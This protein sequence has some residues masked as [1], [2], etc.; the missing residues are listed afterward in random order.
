MDEFRSV[1]EREKPQI[2]SVTETWGKEWMGEAIFSLN[3]YN[4]YRDDRNEKGGG[5]TLLY[6]SKKLGQ[7]AC[8]PLNE[9]AQDQH[10][11]SNIWCW[12]TPMNNSKKFLVGSIY[13]STSSS[14]ENNRLLLKQLERA[15]DIAGENRVLIMGDFNIPDVDWINNDIMVVHQK[16]TRICT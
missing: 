1:I 5:G 13:R 3:D 16:L 8:R 11:E 4:I 12:V 9:V 2:V 10:S 15:N 6:I 14:R 7:R